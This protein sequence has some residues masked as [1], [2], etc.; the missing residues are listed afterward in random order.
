MKTWRTIG[1]DPR[2]VAPMVELS[3]GTVRLPFSGNDL[4]DNVLAVEAVIRVGGQEYHSNPVS[5][6]FREHEAQFFALLGKEPVR[7]LDQDPGPVASVA[8]AT[9][10]AAVFQIQ[11][12]LKAFF[13]HV[14]GL[15]AQHVHDKP[16]STGIVFVSGIIG[17][18]LGYGWFALLRRLPDKISR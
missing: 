13:D 14:I 15:S 7:D 8:L 12:Y 16:D 3:V 10:G 9:A 2:A 6:R 17:G 11:Q 4:L 5:A 18:L 1:S